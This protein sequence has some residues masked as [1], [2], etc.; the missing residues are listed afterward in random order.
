M[1]LAHSPSIV[2]NGL[3]LALDAGNTKSY[4]G[5]GTTW[6]DLSGNGYGGSLVGATTYSTSPSRFDTN[7]TLITEA[8]HLSTS[9]LITFA[10]ASEYT[11]DFW[12]KLRSGATATYHSLAGRG[13]SAPWLT[14]FT[15][16]TAGNSWYLTYREDISGTYNNGSTQ[17]YNIQQNWIN[18]TVSVN[19]NRNL[20]FYFNGTFSETKT[21]TSTLF[22]VNRIAGGYASGGNAYALQG[23]IASSKMYNRTLTASEIQQ[24][25]NA[26][27]SRYGI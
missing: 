2:M 9:S 1:G 6:T 21:P 14:L 8:N 4:P 12:V 24:N 27:R 5:S 7:A 13:T 15:N 11:L 25:F 19:S 3:V 18:I 10:D 16:N 26:I 23:S 20:N 22:Y 17:T